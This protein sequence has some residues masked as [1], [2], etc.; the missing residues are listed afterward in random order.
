MQ[1]STFLPIMKQ[2]LNTVNEN[3]NFRELTVENK[4]LRE[5]V[6]SLTQ[7]NNELLAYKRQLDAMMD[8]APVEVSLK[9]REGRYI[10]VNKKLETLYGVKN[11]NLVGM[12]PTNI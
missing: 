6:L 5:E 2:S 12:F 1:A 4:R 11:E 9:D 8:N 7:S 10:R 3:L